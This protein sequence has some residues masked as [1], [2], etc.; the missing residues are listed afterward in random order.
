MLGGLTGGAG[1]V[2]WVGV[3]ADFARGERAAARVVEPGAGI[4][5]EDRLLE[6]A[7]PDALG[8]RAPVGRLADPLTPTGFVP[9]I[10]SRAASSEA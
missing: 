7:A 4:G 6:V 5:G 1:G 2:P 8:D 3:T 9:Y 10:L